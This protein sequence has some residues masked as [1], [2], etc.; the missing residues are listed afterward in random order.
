[1]EA[2]LRRHRLEIV[3]FGMV[4]FTASYFSHPVDLDNVSSRFFMLSSIVDFRTLS[5]D[6]Y[7]DR[8]GDVSFFGGRHYSNKSI[9]TAVLGVPV[10]WALRQIPPFRDQPP[11]TMPQRYVVRVVTTTLPFAILAITMFRLAKRFGATPRTALW[12]V[13]AYSFGTIALIHASM[14]SGHQTAA[15]FSFFAFAIL[16]YLRNRT[17]SHHEIGL[18]F[19]AGLFAGL[20]ALADY[21]AMFTAM[22]LTIYGFSARIQPRSKLAFLSGGAFCI[23]LLA[24]YNWKCFGSAS[25]ISYAYQVSEEHRK[26]FEQ[27]LFGFRL[28]TAPA[29]FGLLGS[30]SRG[31]LFIMPV[32][33][34]SLYGIFYWWNDQRG[35][36][37]LHV[38]L[39][40][41]L[42][43]LTFVSGF[44]FWHGSTTYG[45]RFL[46]PMLPFLAFPMIFAKV[47]TRWF[48]LTFAASILLVA[49]AMIGLAETRESIMNP[50]V[51]V[52]IPCISR[53]CLSDNLGS[54]LGLE[55]P[56]SILPVVTLSV[57]LGWYATHHLA[58]ATQQ[59]RMLWIEKVGIGTG[60]AVIAVLLLTVRSLPPELVAH[61]CAEIHLNLGNAL[62]ARGDTERAVVHYQEALR[63]NPDFAEVH[64]NLGI[65]L[66]H[67]DKVQEARQHWEQALRIKPDYAKAHYI[68]GLA[69]WQAGK[70]Q[71]AGRH[72]EQALRINPDYAEVHNK[73]G[74][75]LLQTGKL[76]EAVAVSY[77][78]LT[79]PTTPYV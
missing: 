15:S 23:A 2:V 5:L 30:P 1:M 37:E 75:A 58:T 33:I 51:E 16:A 29:L 76:K 11:L 13:L 57:A 48:L 38:I 47:N 6:A 54:W 28:P 44:H 66:W 62:S 7:K 17:T 55:F 67:A 10:Y 22:V 59:S 27:G 72:W 18:A 52:A 26:G 74:N 25:S 12:M 34:F 60:L 39:A 79:L 42:G 69:L 77:T 64:Y 31:L 19:G 3:L 70:V 8:T 53:G 21:T 49:P 50:I 63:I 41:V 35:R 20:A 24:A 9:G 46:V 71:E 68:L 4:L 14:F 40:I 73:L 61:E 43:Y 65:T 32:F 78:H 36:A 56:W 45:P